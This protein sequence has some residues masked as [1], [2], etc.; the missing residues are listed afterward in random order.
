MSVQAQTEGAQTATTEAPTAVFTEESMKK[1]RKVLNSLIEKAW[2]EMDAKLIECK[3]F[4]DKNRGTFEQ[5]MTDIAR[6]AEQI[7]D[8]EKTKAQAIEEILVKDREMHAVVE[9]L[10]MEYAAYMRTYYMNFNTIT[11]HRN[12]MAVFQFMVTLTKCPTSATT[13]LL[14]SAQGP[15]ICEDE[16][17]LRLDFED[18]KA[19]AELERRMTPTARQELIAALRRVQSWMGPSSRKEG[20]PTPPPPPQPPPARGQPPPQAKRWR[21]RTGL[22]RRTG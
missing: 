13:Q 9:K 22:G 12:D 5:V 15:K 20:T 11:S 2:K 4:E 14:Q 6:L 1:A 7:A 21:R 17:G 8:N 10:K 16:H 19:Q 18:T 3:E